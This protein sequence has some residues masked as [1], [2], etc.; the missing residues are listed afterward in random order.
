YGAYSYPIGKERVRYGH[1]ILEA[2]DRRT[3]AV[4][5]QARGTGRVEIPEDAINALPKVIKGIM[6]E[7]PVSTRK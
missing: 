4:I 2:I 5:W 1:I 6:K 7:Y 3:D